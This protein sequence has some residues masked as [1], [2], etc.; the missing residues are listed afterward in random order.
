MHQQKHVAVSFRGTSWHSQAS[1]GR[2]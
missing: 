2:A 1:A